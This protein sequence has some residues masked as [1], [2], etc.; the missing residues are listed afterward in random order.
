MPSGNLGL[1]EHIRLEHVHLLRRCCCIFRKQK[2]LRN[3]DDGLVF[4]PPTW[5]SPPGSEH[6][7]GSNQG[8]HMEI[9]CFSCKVSVFSLLLPSLKRAEHFVFFWCYCVL[10]FSIASDDDGTSSRRS[11]VTLDIKAT[12]RKWWWNTS[13]KTDNMLAE[14]LLTSISCS[15]FPPSPCE[16]RQRRAAKVST[17]YLSDSRFMWSQQNDFLMISIMTYIMIIMTETN[18]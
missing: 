8:F 10:H 18:I 9:K 6:F 17:N 12:A 2:R 4:S 5:S 16:R 1:W 14:N 13:R 7:R 11:P 15:V 3:K